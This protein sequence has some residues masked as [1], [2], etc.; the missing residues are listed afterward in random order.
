MEGGDGQTFE[1]NFGGGGGGMGEIG[2]AEDEEP[3][4]QLK[5]HEKYTWLIGTEWNWYACLAN[6]RVEESLRR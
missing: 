3:K 4:F 6:S 1:M 2:E 5:C